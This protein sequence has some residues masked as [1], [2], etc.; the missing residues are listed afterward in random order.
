MI[1]H[2]ERNVRGKNIGYRDKEFGTILA[3]FISV[4]DN[5]VPY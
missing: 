5:A 3:S 2:A 4:K 1:R